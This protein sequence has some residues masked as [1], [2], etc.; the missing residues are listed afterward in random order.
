MCGPYQRY[1]SR[2]M[3]RRKAIAGDGAVAFV[4]P[5][6]LDINPARQILREVWG[7]NSK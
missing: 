5:G 7:C 6:D 1:N 4:K 2:D 3:R